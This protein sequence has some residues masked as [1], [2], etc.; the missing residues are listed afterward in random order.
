[1]MVNK[2]LAVVVKEE[3]EVVVSDVAKK[4]EILV[5]VNERLAVVAKKED[6]DQSIH[7]A[8]LYN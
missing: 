1:M 2:R 6:M 7:D 5:M 8:N 3:M 4:E